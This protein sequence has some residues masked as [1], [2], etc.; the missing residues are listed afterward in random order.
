MII[1][2]SLQVSFSE[3]EK[4]HEPHYSALKDKVYTSEL[5]ALRTRAHNGSMRQ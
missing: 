4:V 5:Q 1:E 3:V 2:G